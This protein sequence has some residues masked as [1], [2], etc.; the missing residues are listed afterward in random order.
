MLLCWLASQRRDPKQR[1]SLLR[2]L[3]GVHQCRLKALVA[4]VGLGLPSTDM[5]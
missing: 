2:F 1:D 4:T 5:V 3:G